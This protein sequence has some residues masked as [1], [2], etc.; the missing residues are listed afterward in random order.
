MKQDFLIAIA[1]VSAF[2]F[3]AC[4]TKR[5]N[6]RENDLER[7]ADSLEDKAAVVRDETEKKADAIEKG[8]PG[9]NAPA[10]ENAADITRKS[11][12]Q[13]ADAL[14]EAAKREREKK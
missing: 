7:R 6:A 9:P 2:A 11:G 1:G 4:D 5:E 3:S 14:E 12:E 13:T 8:D 10:T